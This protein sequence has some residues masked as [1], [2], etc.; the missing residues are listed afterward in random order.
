MIKHIQYIN[1][2]LLYVLKIIFGI[3]TRCKFECQKDI[4][5]ELAPKLTATASL[6]QLVERCLQIQGRRFNSQ[7]E[8]LEFHFSQLGTFFAIGS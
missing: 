4:H 5:I 3:Y 8:A 7:P 2:T 6:A 1:V